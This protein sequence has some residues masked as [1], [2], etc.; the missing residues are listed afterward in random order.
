M[1]M[2]QV[3]FLVGGIVWIMYPS[4]GGCTFFV[5]PR[6]F[7]TLVDCFFMTYMIHDMVETSKFS[8]SYFS[9]NLPVAEEVRVEGI[10]TTSGKSAGECLGMIHVYIQNDWI[11]IVNILF[12]QNLP[13]NTLLNLDH[14]PLYLQYSRFTVSK[15]SSKTYFCSF[16]LLPFETFLCNLFGTHSITG[17]HADIIG[18]SSLHLQTKSWWKSGLGP[19]GGVRFFFSR[20][21]SL[22][23]KSQILFSDI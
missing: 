6:M 7:Q 19:Q 11:Y 15:S 10:S 3:E 2:Q 20:L 21:R 23:E 1:W 13:N 9:V 12:F 22:D 14:L 18:E 8:E 17:R 16:R 4:N 5:W